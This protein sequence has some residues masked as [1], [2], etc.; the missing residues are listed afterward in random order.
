MECPRC[1]VENENGH[2]YCTYCRAEL[3]TGMAFTKE[4]N[5]IEALP[6]KRRSQVLQSTWRIARL[7]LSAF[8]L[9]LVIVIVR[10]IN[11]N[12][13]M[14]GISETKTGVER[15]LPKTG[16]FGN[17]TVVP[18]PHKTEE[19]KFT[20]RNIVEK[21]TLSGLFF[22]LFARFRKGF[23]ENASFGAELRNAQS[24]VAVKSS[25]GGLTLKSTVRAK[26]YLDGQFL[27]FTPQTIRLTPGEH[28]VSLLAEGYE[29][30]NRKIRMKAG[31][32]INL[33]TSLKKI[34]VP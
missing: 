30:W 23:G 8:L 5:E 11:W 22:K 4:A 7:V 21:E 24:V 6:P 1:Q 18:T 26:M 15:E 14:R 20:P 27:G 28:K 32:Q 31:K 9:F 34:R 12:S 17:S 13:L 25:M 16:K 10:G 33:K 29:G 19:P 2:S 3:S